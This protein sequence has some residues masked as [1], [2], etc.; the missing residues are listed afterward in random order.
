MRTRQDLNDEIRVRQQMRDMAIA[1]GVGQTD[2][3]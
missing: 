3:G 2:E 1:E